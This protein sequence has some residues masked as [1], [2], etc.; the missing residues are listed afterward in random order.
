MNPLYRKILFIVIWYFVYPNVLLIILAPEIF[1]KSENLI[2]LFALLLSYL[3]G[4]ID[5]LIRP[6]SESIQKDA[7]TNPLYSVILVIMFLFNPLFI[8]LSF[9]ESKHLTSD[10]VP[11]WDNLIVS[12]FGILILLIG[13]F[14]LIIGRYQLKQF[15]TGIL[16]IEENHQLITTGIFNY[17][18]HPIYAG[19]L[20]GIFGFYFAYRSLLVLLVVSII[21]FAI[22]R[23][24]LLF[25]EKLLIEEFKE[26]YIEYMKQ[27]KRL[28]PFLY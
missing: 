12:V 6:F 26:Q 19:G 18:R 16:N 20:L 14:I 8:V 5:T 3:L 4:I 9:Y 1:L 15:G 17:I 28:I 25:E 21:Y 13:G 7:T 10:Y 11:F 24:R 2:F 22:F 23:H 27:T